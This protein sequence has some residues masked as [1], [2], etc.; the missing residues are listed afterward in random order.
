MGQL[1]ELEQNLR[2]TGQLAPAPSASMASEDSGI[3]DEEASSTSSLSPPSSSAS[4]LP[5]SPIERDF[6]EDA[7]SSSCLNPPAPPIDCPMNQ[8][9]KES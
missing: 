2:A 1:L 3:V 9:D 4:S 5:T 6:S 8:P 7:T